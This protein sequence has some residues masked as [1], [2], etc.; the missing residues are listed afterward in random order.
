MI[1]LDKLLCLDPAFEKHEIIE[2]DDLS[3]SPIYLYRNLIYKTS[4][5]GPIIIINIRLFQLREA[6]TDLWNND[7]VTEGR[8]RA[9]A[10]A[11][12]AARRIQEGAP[13]LSPMIL[14]QE[15]VALFKDHS[16][17]KK[18]KYIFLFY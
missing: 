17:Y 8:A 12:E 4:G 18:Q 13:P 9:S 15:L 3:L 1:W 6:F 16:K 7:L 2:N 5:T 14:Y 10:W 11:H